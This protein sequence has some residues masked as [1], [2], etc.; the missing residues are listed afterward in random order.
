MIQSDN[1]VF[2]KKG[3]SENIA[4]FNADGAVELYYDNSKR[5]ETHTQGAAIASGSMT[6]PA[7]NSFSSQILVGACLLYTSP[8]PRAS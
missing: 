8:R 4:I 2:I 3:T 6:M 5:I 1:A 7:M